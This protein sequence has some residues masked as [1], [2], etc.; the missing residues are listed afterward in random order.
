MK[1]S[2]RKRNDWP[3]NEQSYNRTREHDNHQNERAHVH[4]FQPNILN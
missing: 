1:P 4:S 3:N 2:K